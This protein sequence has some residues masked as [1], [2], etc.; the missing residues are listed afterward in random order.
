[1]IDVALDADRALGM[2]RRIG[3]RANDPRALLERAGELL[4]DYER[5]V[6]A[7]AGLGD[8]PADDPATVRAKGSRRVLVDSGGLLAD[9]SRGPV[10]F[11]GTDAVEVTSRAIGGVMAQRGA[12]GPKRD[13]T[14]TPPAT[15]QAR[16]AGELLD[17]LLEGR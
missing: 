3:G 1:M 4:L 7:S 15:E 11:V 5:R 2:L 13:P 14:P 8:W 9:L 16:W 6:F 12:H 10:R 17:V